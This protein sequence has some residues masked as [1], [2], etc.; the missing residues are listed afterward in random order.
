MSVMGNSVDVTIFGN[1]QEL[2]TSAKYIIDMACFVLYNNTHFK[3][4][5]EKEG[6]RKRRKKTTFSARVHVF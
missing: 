4:I 3:S 6:I 1:K 5:E 2:N